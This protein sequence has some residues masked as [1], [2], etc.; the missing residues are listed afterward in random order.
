MSDQAGNAATPK[1]TSFTVD[2]Q[3]PG[4]ATIAL[5]TDSGTPSDGVSNVGTISVGNLEA[6]SSW[7]YS[8]NAGTSWLSGTGTSFTLSEGSYSA[9][10]VQ[11]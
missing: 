8:V 4:A 6:G 5:Q 9:N 10:Q 3:A 7:Q 1:T 2:T 11:V